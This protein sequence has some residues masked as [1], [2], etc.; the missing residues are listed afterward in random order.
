MD[1]N[2]HIMNRDSVVQ[3]LFI[4]SKPRKSH[5]REYL[6]VIISNFGEEILQFLRSC[7]SYISLLGY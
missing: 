5:G 1:A 4:E 2:K 7:F 6:F 3:F